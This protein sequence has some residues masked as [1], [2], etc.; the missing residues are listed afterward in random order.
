MRDFQEYKI[1]KKLFIWNRKYYVL[2]ADKL[3]GAPGQSNAFVLQSI[4]TFFKYLN[5]CLNV[6][7]FPKWCLL[8]HG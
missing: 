1:C 4:K 2:A 8:L 6:W 3:S 7:V 5:I